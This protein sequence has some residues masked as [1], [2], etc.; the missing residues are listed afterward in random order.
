MRKGQVFIQCLPLIQHTTGSSPPG[1]AA[2]AA[3]ITPHSFRFS[4]NDSGNVARPRANVADSWTGA[5]AS[6]DLWVH[7]FLGNPYTDEHIKANVCCQ[8]YLKYPMYNDM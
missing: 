2:T 6:V 8:L 3:P 5:A 4:F 1:F 7:G